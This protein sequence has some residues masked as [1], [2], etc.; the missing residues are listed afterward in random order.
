MG[1]TPGQCGTRN[2]QSSWA[3]RWA[4]SQ[5]KRAENNGMVGG[6][7]VPMCSLLVPGFVLST[8]GLKVCDNSSLS[9]NVTE[10]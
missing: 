3:K 1:V 9:T 7:R 8:W 5:E 6:C 4:V 2:V 10:T